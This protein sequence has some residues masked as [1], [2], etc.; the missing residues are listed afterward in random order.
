[1]GEGT[2]VLS[3]KRRDEMENKTTIDQLV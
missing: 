3:K 1:M 2:S